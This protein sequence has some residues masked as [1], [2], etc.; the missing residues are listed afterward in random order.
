MVAG[1]LAYLAR[2]RFAPTAQLLE[3]RMRD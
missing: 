3:Q 1:I 2:S